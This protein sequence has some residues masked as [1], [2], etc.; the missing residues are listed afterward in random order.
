MINYYIITIFVI[1]QMLMLEMRNYD[2]SWPKVKE[3]PRKNTAR[4]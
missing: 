2:G 3:R 1:F 4:K